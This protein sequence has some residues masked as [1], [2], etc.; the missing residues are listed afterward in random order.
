MYFGFYFGEVYDGCIW[1]Y[2]LVY[3]GRFGVGCIKF[4]ILDFVYIGFDIVKC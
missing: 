1:K 4:I 3:V 2:G